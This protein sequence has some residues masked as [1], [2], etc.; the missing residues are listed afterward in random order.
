MLSLERQSW[1]NVTPDR[2]LDAHPPTVEGIGLATTT[3]PEI[4]RFDK[5][6]SMLCSV[7]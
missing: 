1:R 5:A 7:L 3:N 6:I 4:C 2:E